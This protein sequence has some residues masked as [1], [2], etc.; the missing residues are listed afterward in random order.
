MDNLK[1]GKV[2]VGRFPEI[3]HE[4]RISDSAFSKQLPTIMLFRD[5]NP[6]MYRPIVDNNGKLAKFHFNKENVITTFDLNNLHTELK[7]ILADKEKNR[8]ASSIANAKHAK[9]E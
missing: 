8:K 3:A 9:A 6:V 5:G 2:D 1:F 4:F 7:K